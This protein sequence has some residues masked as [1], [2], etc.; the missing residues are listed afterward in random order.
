VLTYLCDAYCEERGVDAEGKEK[1]R[2]V[3]KLH[4]KLAPFKFA[5][6]PLM[7]KDGLAEAAGKIYEEVHALSG[8]YGSY[9]EQQ[10]I[11]KRYS[12]HDEVGTPFCLTVTD[13]TVTIRERDTTKQE[14]VT[15]AEAARRVKTAVMG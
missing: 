5:V 8:Q 12:R 2:T 7:K 6:L 11:G 1:V 14:R 4:P 15:V 3:L 13:G 9:E 10:S